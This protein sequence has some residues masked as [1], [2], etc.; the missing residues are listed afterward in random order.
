[1]PKSE[2]P[3][4]PDDLTN[5]EKRALIRWTREKHPFFCR[6]SAL[7]FIV[8]E[9]LNHHRARGNAS[10]YRDWPAVIRNRIMSLDARGLDEFA[11]PRRVNEKPQEKRGRDEQG[12]LRKIADVVN[13][14]D[15]KK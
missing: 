5:E 8:L 3:P 14:G 7:R 11:R 1:M 2:I 6:A 13:L 10:R 4:V 15:Y 12:E 9:T